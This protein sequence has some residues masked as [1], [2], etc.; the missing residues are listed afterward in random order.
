MDGWDLGRH[1]ATIPAR[2]SKAASVRA[3][4]TFAHRQGR[5]HSRK[6]RKGREGGKWARDE[7]LHN[8]GTHGALATGLGACLP[9]A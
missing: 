9:R 7:G 5:G 6:R 4:D 3:S 8:W 1:K 2:W